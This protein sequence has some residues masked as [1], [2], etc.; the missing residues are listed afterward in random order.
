MNE[1][2][3][4]SSAAIYHIRFQGRLDEKW[5]SWFQGFAMNTRENGETLLSG[6]I[7]DQAELFGILAKINNLGLP[8]LMVMRVD[9]PCREKKCARHGQC[10]ECAAHYE[11]IGTTP[12]CFRT[13]TK[14]DRQFS[15]LLESKGK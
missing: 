11:N 13:K 12:F 2:S 3:L 5:A 1:K 7:I 9:C 10:Q 6:S 8:L 14:W 15:L 4:R